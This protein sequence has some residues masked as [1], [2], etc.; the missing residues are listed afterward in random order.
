MSSLFQTQDTI[1]AL[2]TAPGEGAI[3]IVRLSGQQALHIASQVFSGPIHEYASH[4]VHLG[5]IRFQQQRID[6]ALVLV[7]R[8]PRSYTG[9]DIVELHCHGGMIASK[10]VLEA[11]LQCGARLA[12]PGEF[13]FRAFMNGKLDLS[14]AEA[15]QSLIGA[16]NAQSL[17]HAQAHLEGALSKKIRS[18]QDQLLYVAAVCEAWVDF[19]DE[20]IEF[21]S[22]EE[23]LLLLQNV[24]QQICALI[25]SFEDGKKL[26]QGISLAIIG[27]P[28]AGKS[29]LLNAL[30]EEER[31]IVTPIPGT[32]RDLLHEELTIGGLTFRLTDTAG[33]RETEE[34]VE[35]EGIR[36]A[37]RAMEQ[38]DWI[39]VVL[40]LTR[41][42]PSLLELIPKEKAIFVL[43]KIDLISKVPQFP[44]THHI[45]VSARTGEGIEEL[46]K[47]LCSHIW[48]HGAPDQEELILSSHRHKQILVH[49]ADAIERVLN[50]LEQVTSPEWLAA[51]LRLALQSLGE[52]LGQD[53][54][55]EVLGKIF[56][57][58]CIGK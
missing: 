29:S 47:F 36:R 2:S 51:D 10:R 3:A 21:T 52:V 57:T 48:K 24:Y 38:A 26:F 45:A 54:T 11:V 39:L 37:Y 18:F 22:K 35:Q 7:M 31:A 56:S 16:K 27:E 34:S 32:T 58:F 8:A 20:G 53:V 17:R 28:N 33:L 55:E 1:A 9:E 23:L 49:A 13:T 43:N 41:P 12:H 5:A 42:L 40:D 30:V 25:A 50:G 46:K 44:F 4:T 6:Q 15:V 14:Q 19:P